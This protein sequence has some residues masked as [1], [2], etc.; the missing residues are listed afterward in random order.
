M[1]Q[2]ISLASSLDASDL[3]ISPSS[4]NQQAFLCHHQLY[5]FAIKVKSISSLVV[6]RDHL[7]SHH[8]SYMKQTYFTLSNILSLQT[9]QSSSSYLHPES[10]I[11]FFLK[12]LYATHS[13]DIFRLS[14]ATQKSFTNSKVLLRKKFEAISSISHQIERRCE[15]I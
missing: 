2:S 3:I 6:L 5:L 14:R 4:V 7:R 13:L 1:F 12:K 15:D 10:S 11:S 8:F 9:T